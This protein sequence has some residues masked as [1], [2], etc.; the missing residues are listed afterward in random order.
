MVLLEGHQVNRA[1]VHWLRLCAAPDEG[2]QSAA[3]PRQRAEASVAGRREDVGSA[4]FG[5]GFFEVGFAG[6]AG[7]AIGGEDASF[8]SCKSGIN[9]M[10]K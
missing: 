7:V 5:A 6:C 8:I 4:G 2:N 9:P 10:D 1:V 3:A